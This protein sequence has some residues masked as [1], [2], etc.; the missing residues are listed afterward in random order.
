MMMVAWAAVAGWA[1]WRRSGGGPRTAEPGLDIGCRRI[2]LGVRCSRARRAPLAGVRTG[3]RR[4]DRG[5]Q[6]A[7][8]FDQ[9]GLTFDYPRT[10]TPESWPVESSFSSLIT[11]LSPLALHDPCIRAAYSISCGYPLTSLTPAGVLI[12]WE[13]ISRPHPPN[14]TQVTSPNTTI[15]GQTAS[16]T[17]AHPGDCGP[18]GADETITAEILRPPGGLLQMTACLRAPDTA[19]NEALVRQMLAS[20]Q[21][22]PS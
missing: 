9:Y 12:S 14:E 16:L 6:R 10:W 2:G 7:R 13:E 21:V 20:V 8:R 19:M 15:G 3:R 5:Q 17:V 11:Y 22:S 18:I 1:P 4:G